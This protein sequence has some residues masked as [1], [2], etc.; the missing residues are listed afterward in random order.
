MIANYLIGVDD[1][2]NLESRGTG[3]RARQ[4]GMLINDQGVARLN[5]VTRHQLFVSPEI[6]YTSHNSSACLSVSGDS[7]NYLDLIELCKQYL[8]TESASGSDAGLCVARRD[9]V[10]RSVIDFGLRAKC[11][12]L[13]KDMALV[14]AQTSG[15]YLEGLT[16]QRIGVIGALSAV[17]LHQSGNDGRFLWLPGLRELGECYSVEELKRLGGIDLVRTQEG[18]IILSSQKVFVGDWPRPI[19]QDGKSV[20]LVQEEQQH[21]G[22][23]WRILPR[24]II[25]ELSR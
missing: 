11:Q 24:E 18:E 13:T 10:N 12:V 23:E 21:D 17:G 14:T 9:L 5:S 19:L 3:F 22:Y 6:P 2:D 25:K 16:G 15:I 20:L 8:L 4:L 1:T 7:Q